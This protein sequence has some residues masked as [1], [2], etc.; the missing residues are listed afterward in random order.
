MGPTEVMDVN[1][2]EKVASTII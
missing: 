1:S 2:S